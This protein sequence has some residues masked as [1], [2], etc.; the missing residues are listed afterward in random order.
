[1]GNI[2]SRTKIRTFSPS[3]H[4]GVQAL[5]PS[6]RSSVL[7]LQLRFQIPLW[8]RFLIFGVTWGHMK[9][10]DLNPNR[11]CSAESLLSN[12]LVWFRVQ[13]AERS[14]LEPWFTPGGGTRREEVYGGQ[15]SD[16][17]ALRSSAAVRSAQ[18]KLLLRS[19]LCHCS[20]STV[21]QVKGHASV[22]PVW[23]LLRCHP[24]QVPAFDLR[25][26]CVTDEKI[27]FMQM[28]CFCR[29]LTTSK[30]LMTGKTHKQMSKCVCAHT[31]VDMFM[32]FLRVCAR[33]GM[34]V[35]LWV[36]ACFFVYVCVCIPV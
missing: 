18:T 6:V 2:C 25:D 34:C 30:L 28:T 8:G 23:V 3:P 5:K 27:R 33:T 26:W 24:Q 15:I 31:C 10:S 36:H 1:M 19:C 13:T 29:K 32:H 17:T 4:A 14:E 35:C 21:L 22:Q 16:P 12:T 11:L 9:T 20:S 7:K